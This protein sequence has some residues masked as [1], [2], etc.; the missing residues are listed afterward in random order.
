MASNVV[1]IGLGN[2]SGMFYHSPLT[3]TAPTMPT[4][5]FDEMTGFTEVGY[6]SEDGPSWTP[7][8]STET[9]RA[10]DLSVKRVIKTEK[11]SVTVP[12]I[13]TTQESLKTI[14]GAA[15]VTHTAATTTHGVIDKVDT[16]NGPYTVDE[17]FVLVGKDGED[18]LML[19]CASG[20]VTEV[21][22]IGLAPNGAIVWEITITGDWAFT[23][24]DGQSTTSP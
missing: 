23:K 7:Y 16:A 18:G 9:I 17:A 22:E 19:S 15:A 13:S 24:D 12:V 5:P 8:G 21:S 11:G 20:R 4:S 14:F 3:P 1:N 10:W 6:V 2:A